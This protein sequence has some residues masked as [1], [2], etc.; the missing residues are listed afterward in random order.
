MSVNKAILVG[1]IGRDPETRFTGGGTAVANF[2]VATEESFKDRSG[3]KQKKT[4]WHRI[5]TW[6]KLAEIVQQYVTKGMLVYIEGSIGTR[7]WKDKE[8]NKRTS[9]E[10]TARN[11]RMLGGGTRKDGGSN[12]GGEDSHWDDQEDRDSRGSSSQGT[13]GPEIADDDIPF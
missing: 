3:N 11:L 5:I 6:G 7:E 1:R 13:S 8:G 2:S 10:I 4:E 12:A 9:T